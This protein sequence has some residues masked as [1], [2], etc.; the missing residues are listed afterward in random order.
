MATGASQTF[1]AGRSIGHTDSHN[2][3]TRNSLSNSGNTSTTN[4]HADNYRTY[5]D[6]KHHEFKDSTINGSVT[7]NCSSQTGISK[8]IKK[9]RVR[10]REAM[11]TLG[12]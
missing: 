9:N 6:A 12:R 10:T 7:I 8:K 4:S 5:H 1:S 2:P 11:E 3:T